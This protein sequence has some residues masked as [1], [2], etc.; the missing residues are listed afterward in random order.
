MAT[1]KTHTIVSLDRFAAILGMSPVHFNQI[2][3]P[4]IA[5][6]G[7]CASVI[8]QYDWQAADKASRETIAIA[9]QNAE[10]QIANLLGYDVGPI[11]KAED[12]VELQRPANPELLAT[13]GRSI[14][15]QGISVRASKGYV[16]T[17]GTKAK[18]VIDSGASVAYTDVDNDTYDETATIVVN[19]TV[20]RPS[21]ICLFY[22]GESGSDDWQIRPITVS[23]A[24]GVATITCRREQLVV[25][26]ELERFGAQDLDGTVDANF[27]TEV[28][29]YRVY[30][31]PAEQ[32]WII[33]EGSGCCGCGT[34]GY[35]VQSACLT[36]RDDR[37]A[38]LNIAPGTWNNDDND[39]DYAE[40]YG[41]RAPDRARLWYKAG[42]VYKENPLI[43]D[44]VWERAVCYLALTYISDLICTCPIVEKKQTF[45]KED[46]ALRSSS[47]NS[48]RSF[49]HFPELDNP[50]GTSR[51]ALNAWKL[52]K[53]AAIGGLNI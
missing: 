12:R 31:N 11:W 42:W 45:W 46:M 19:T 30:N 48:S 13:S 21:E 50:L 33:W 20:T 17:G 15:G 16:I 23:I 8:Y 44:P 27:L 34:C 40:F 3:I 26:E 39:F 38:V 6:S 51:A 2:H 22:P 4:E 25:K 43:I 18:S 49:Q 9:I 24:G 5:D 36:V 47:V 29:V 14:R 53:P 28:D 1:A 7:S 35:T 10:E 52:I 32:A 37:L 41:C